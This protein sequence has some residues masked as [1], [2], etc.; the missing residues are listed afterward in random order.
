MLER[1]DRLL[2]ES[3]VAA[4]AVL[5]RASEDESFD[6]EIRAEA[7][8]ALGQHTASHRSSGALVEALL[9]LRRGEALSPASPRARGRLALTR[10]YLAFRESRDEEAREQLA[11][12]IEQLAPWPRAQARALDVLGMLR[13]RSGDLDGAHESF[14]RAVRLKLADPG[15]PDPHSLALTYG[16]L[17]RLSLLRGRHQ[18]AEEWLRKDLELILALD[19]KPVTEAHVRNQLAQA[20]EAQGPGRAGDAEQELERARQIAPRGTVTYLYVLKSAALMRFEQGR[21]EEG[22]Q[23]LDELRRRARADSFPEMDPWIALL[24][25]KEKQGRRSARELEQAAQHYERARAGFQ[26]RKMPAEA[27]DA[28]LALAAVQAMRGDRTQASALLREARGRVEQQAP[29]RQ[30]LLG[31]L[32]AQ[33]A[34]LPSLR[35]DALGVRVRRAVRR[36]WGGASSGEGADSAADEASEWTVCVV[37]FRGQDEFWGLE[38]SRERQVQQWAR[39]SSTVADAAAGH[40]ARVDTL[41]PDRVVMR[42]AGG[43]SSNR[44]VEALGRVSA[45]LREVLS[46]QQEVSFGLTAG[47]AVG[48]CAQSSLNGGGRSD[49]V[50]LGPAVSMATRLANLASAGEILLTGDCLAALSPANL[51]RVEPY[52]VEEDLHRLPF[53]GR[54]SQR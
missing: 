13:S 33:L 42:F 31:S 23:L 1:A 2:P 21:Q 16:N 15:D 45:R 14:E 7:L 37:A 17:G 53:L 41:S 34:R 5:E 30:D 24:E 54:T 18:E 35:G 48:W 8:A 52:A 40:G 28:A 6:P 47:L 3:P 26:L 19:P 12:S 39:L 44:A 49:R 4:I 27:C 11:L 29:Y 43:S 9:Y 22:S 32:D 38:S 51:P 10:G 36:W 46:P 50:I 20:L 25:G